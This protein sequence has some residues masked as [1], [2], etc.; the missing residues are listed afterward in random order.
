VGPSA[1]RLPHALVWRPAPAPQLRIPSVHSS[2]ITPPEK[3]FSPALRQPMSGDDCPLATDKRGRK[4]DGQIT[5]GRIGAESND[6]QRVVTIL[7]EARFQFQDL[8]DIVGCHTVGGYVLDI[9]VA[10]LIPK[11]RVHSRNFVERLTNHTTMLH[12]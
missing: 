10:I 4:H 9:A 11:E 2:S 1:A 6:T 3:V 7:E 8:R 5:P 12:D